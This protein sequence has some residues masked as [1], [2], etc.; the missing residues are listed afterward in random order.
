M[1]GAAADGGHIAI[2][3]GNGDH[4]FDFEYSV[5][6]NG[7]LSVNSGDGNKSLSLWDAGKSG[8][9]SAQFGDGDHRILLGGR[10]SFEGGTA[11]IELGNGDHSFTGQFGAYADVEITSGSGEQSYYFYSDGFAWG[12]LN[13]TTGAGAQSF[14]FNG[15]AARGGVVNISAGEGGDSFEF[16]Q[17]SASLGGVVTLDLGDDADVDT[18]NLGF[19]P[20]TIVIQN[21]VVGVDAKV[22]VYGDEEGGAWVG[23]DDGQDIVF[24]F[25]SANEEYGPTNANITFEG[26][27]WWFHRPTRLLHVALEGLRKPVQ[28]L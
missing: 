22:N 12:V 5:R 25:D 13:L 28:S 21:Y 1:G 2:E 23:T 7:S 24:T 14:S 19:R 17:S 20:E 11:S 6:G 4:R 8:S 3:T 27:G 18:V 26:F 10:N 16:D 15:D 9:L